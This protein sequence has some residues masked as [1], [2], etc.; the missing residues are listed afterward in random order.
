M[1]RLSICND[2]AWSV[3][4]GHRIAVSLSTTNWPI[5]WPSPDLTT[6]TLHLAGCWLD[7]PLRLIDP[8]DAPPGDR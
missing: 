6:L 7:L 1:T 5:A 8:A 3:P 2:I 4:P